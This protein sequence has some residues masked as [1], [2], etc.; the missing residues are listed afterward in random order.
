MSNL[1]LQSL[2]F[3]Y[4]FMIIILFFTK[5]RVK[6]VETVLFTIISVLNMIGIILDLIIVYL[7][8]THPFHPSLILLNKFYLLYIL[9]WAGIFTSYIAHISMSDKKNGL[10]VFTYSLGVISFISTTLV[11]LLPIELINNLEIMYTDGPSV[12]VVY[13]TCAVFIFFIIVISL[14]SI[15]KIKNKKY[16]PIFALLILSVLAFIVRS[17][18]PA[19]LLTTSIM[20]AINVLMYHTIE[21]PDVKMLKE[22]ALAKDQ[23]EMANLAKSDFLSSMSH[24]IRTPLNAIKSFTEFTASTT[25]I[26]EANENSKEVLK[27]VDI[28][29]ELINGVLDISKIESGN[30]EVVNTEY[31][32]VE[33]INDVSKLINIRMKEKNLKFTINI[34][35]DIPTTLYGDRARIQQVLINLLTNAAKY[36]PEGKVT[37][38][39]NAI[40]QKN[41][42]RLIISVEDTGRG[43][44]PE[45]IEKL[46]TKFNRLEEHMNTTAEGTGLGLAISKQ[47]IELMGGKISVNSVYGTGSKFTASVN[48]E[49]I[50]PAPNKTPVFIPDEKINLRTEEEV[51]EIKTEDSFIPVADLTNKKVLI[52]DD[53]KVNLK[54]AERFLKLYNINPE[55]CITPFEVIDKLKAGET[56]D[57][58]L[59]DDMMPN[60]SGTELM[61]KL[62]SEGNKIPMIVLTANAKVGD[63]EEYI[64]QGFD[65]YIAKP[66]DKNIFFD[67]LTKYLED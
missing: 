12:N 24:E 44:K 17:I 32:P 39:V 54:V 23:A 22:T 65:D 27:A 29:L 57:L 42:C 61:Q 30:M 53:N 46:F 37:L 40:N 26:T 51:K 63:K 43:I 5:K 1:Y 36:T 52:V 16:L 15:K 9:Y 11:F 33:F 47:L 56:Y 58:L 67:V 55:L 64:K 10:C 28:L 14:T 3:I 6:N 45:S 19:L 59:I 34:A 2:S 41:V 7:S 60:M 62:K 21:N 38:S 35:K 50:D 13:F 31:N 49:I 25:D 8:Y 18:N 20:T 4:M 48:Q 66:I